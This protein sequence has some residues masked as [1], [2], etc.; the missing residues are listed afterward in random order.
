[1]HRTQQIAKPDE[2]IITDNLA[3]YDLIDGMTNNSKLIISE[4]G[5]DY[6]LGKLKMVRHIDNFIYE[7]TVDKIFGS[8]NP[9]SKKLVFRIS[10]IHIKENAFIVRTD[11]LGEQL[12]S[13]EMALCEKLIHLSMIS[14]EVVGINGK[15]LL[16]FVS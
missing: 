6:N 12:N 11:F 1:M 7:L 15:Y 10:N 8:L 3:I 5:R 4:P 2:K 16:N 9:G 13:D 14:E